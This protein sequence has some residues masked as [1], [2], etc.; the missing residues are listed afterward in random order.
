MRITT[1]LPSAY[2]QVNNLYRPPPPCIAW[3]DR[4]A[5]K[6]GQ[7]SVFP[8]ERRSDLVRVGGVHSMKV[9]E[10]WGRRTQYP[11]KSKDPKGINWGQAG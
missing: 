7:G 3:L 4:D 11:M 5:C 10:Q 8:A 1:V 2:P 6:T 9:D